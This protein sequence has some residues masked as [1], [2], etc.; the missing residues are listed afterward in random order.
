MTSRAKSALLWG[1]LGMLAFLVA[2]QAYL[3]LGGAFLGVGAVGAVAVVVFAATTSAAY[4]VEGR[5][6]GARPPGGDG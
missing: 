3:L 1:A 5:L 2:H 4:Y 6:V